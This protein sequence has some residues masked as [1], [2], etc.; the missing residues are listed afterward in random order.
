[1]RLAEQVKD[2]FPGLE[3]AEGLAEHRATVLD[4]MARGEAICAVAD[5]ELLGALLFLRGE[6][7]LCFLVVSGSCRRKGIA[8][9]LVAK[10]LEEMPAGRDVT[11]TTYREGVP[12]GVA[13]RAFYRRLGFVEGRL[14]EE[15]GA[16]V[17]EFV[18]QR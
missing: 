18:L 6:C 3:T 9:R 14:T 7:V 15:F 1:M 5:G 2:S 16:P 12:D 10:M 8:E 11:V 4:F 13:A 17:Q